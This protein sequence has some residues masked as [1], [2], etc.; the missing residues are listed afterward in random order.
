MTV[1]A[2][3]VLSEVTEMMYSK[4]KRLHFSCQYDSTI[5]EDIRFQQATPQGA[6]DMH[7]DNPVALEKFK[8][9]AAYYVDFTPALTA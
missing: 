1:R 6:F 2:K 4:G 9:G 7:C 5:P 3:L 8:L